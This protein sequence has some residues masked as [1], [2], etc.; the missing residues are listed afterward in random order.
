ML[1]LS[2][3]H[4]VIYSSFDIILTFFFYF[5][6]EFNKHISSFFFS[7]WSIFVLSFWISDSSCFFIIIKWCLRIWNS[8]WKTV[9]WLSISWSFFKWDFSPTFHLQIHSHPLTVYVDM[10]CFSLFLCILWTG[11]SV[12]EHPLLTV[13]FFCAVS[14]LDST[15]G[16]SGWC[17][18][19]LCFC[20]ILNFSLF[21]FF[22]SGDTLWRK[23]HNCISDSLPKQCFSKASILNPSIF[24]EL[25]LLSTLYKP[26]FSILH[27]LLEFLFPQVRGLLCFTKDLWTILFF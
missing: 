15:V 25:V 1:L 26:V 9:L 8:I 20:K 16:R 18:F 13:P 10:F 14:F 6:S 3:R 22:S 21:S 7:F 12:W 23:A 4:L 17:V 19:C 11:L 27:L 5:F 24:Q 2:L